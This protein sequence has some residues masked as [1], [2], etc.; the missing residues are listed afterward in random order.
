MDSGLSALRPRPGMTLSCMATVCLF[1]QDEIEVPSRRRVDFE[2]LE[3]V[4]AAIGERMLH[5]GGNVDHVVL[6]N[7]I[8]LSFDHERALATLDDVDVVGIGMVMQLAA[9]ASG[10]EPIEVNVDLLGAE[11]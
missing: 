11:A 9:R 7:H 10:N 3:R 8:G 2:N 5:S 6:A 1:V 4:G